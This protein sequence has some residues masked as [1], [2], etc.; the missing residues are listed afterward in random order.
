MPQTFPRPLPTGSRQEGVNVAGADGVGTGKKK[1][2]PRCPNPYI[3]P[4]VAVVTYGLALVAISL[5]CPRTHCS[6]TPCPRIPP[7]PKCP[8]TH[9]FFTPCPRIPRTESRPP[10]TA[11]ASAQAVNTTQTWEVEHGTWHVRF[12]GLTG[13]AEFLIPYYSEA[14]SGQTRTRSSGARA[15]SRAAPAP[16]S[17]APKIRVAYASKLIC[18]RKHSTVEQRSWLCGGDCH[19]SVSSRT[20]CGPTAPSAAYTPPR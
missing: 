11:A 7:S 14:H 9:C 3:K 6:F 18:A 5:K 2:A 16:P 12:C 19:V 15:S 8:R 17:V 20:Q 13:G 1:M 10:E 4:S